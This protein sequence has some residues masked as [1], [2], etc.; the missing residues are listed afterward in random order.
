M[1]WQRLMAE[2]RARHGKLANFLSKHTSIFELRARPGGKEIRLVPGSGGTGGGPSPTVGPEVPTV[3]PLW[4]ER[5]HVSS[6]SGAAGGGWGQAQMPLTRV[7]VAVG[8]EMATGGVATGLCGEGTGGGNLNPG[9]GGLDLLRQMFCDNCCKLGHLYS[10]CP[11]LPQ[12]HVCGS[13]R[14]AKKDCPKKHE[15]CSACGKIGHLKVVCA[16]PTSMCCACEG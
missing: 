4:D 10:V 11:S 1:Q 3:A 5:V 16:C 15:R 14:H 8:S 2:I 9:L 7:P 6:L 12:C 13:V